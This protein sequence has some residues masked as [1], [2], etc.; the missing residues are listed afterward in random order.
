MSKRLDTKNRPVTGNTYDDYINQFK[1]S[2]I[3]DIKDSYPDLKT[4]E[5]MSL[6]KILAATGV[7]YKKNPAAI[8]ENICSPA[9]PEE[10]K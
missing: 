1:S 3:C 9:K 10:S 4:D 7:Q 2:L 8:Q 5:S 6:P